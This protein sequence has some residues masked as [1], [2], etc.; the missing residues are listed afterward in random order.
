MGSIKAAVWENQVGSGTRHSVTLRRV[1][2]DGEQWKTTESF[3]RDDLLVV[4]KVADQAHTW[5][6]AHR[7]AAQ[8]DR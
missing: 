6:C 3:G 1:Y 5:I 4:A 8:T 7:T 2:K